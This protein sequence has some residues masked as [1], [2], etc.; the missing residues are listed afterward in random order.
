MLTPAPGVT[1]KKAIASSVGLLL[2]ASLVAGVAQGKQFVCTASTAYASDPEG[3][4]KTRDGVLRSN[5]TV[6]TVDTSTGLVQ[7]DPVV[8]PGSYT[9]IYAGTG[10][11]GAKLL[12][13]EAARLEVLFI[14]TNAKNP[15][16]FLFTD[17]VVS[18]TG[19]CRPS[20]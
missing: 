2:T 11:D 14:A 19:T 10:V 13:N 16:P 20:S 5:Q 17:G 7:G 12:R 1:V 8:P 18:I 9:V 3:R 6:F 15:H 4:L